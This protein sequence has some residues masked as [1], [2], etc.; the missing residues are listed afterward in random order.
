VTTIVSKLFHVLEPE[1]AFFGQKDAA[2]LAVIRRMVRD[3][4]FAVE[5]VACSI[6]REPDGL[7][8]SS[9]N[10]Y[11]NGEERSRALVLQRSLQETRQRFQAG[12]RIAANLI[13]AANEVIR[14]VPQ[15]AL[16]YFEIVDPETLDP[17][18]RVSQKTLVAVAAYVGS[19]RL[20]DNVVL[21]P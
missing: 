10:A 7:A 14:R 12:E 4:N 9:R 16:D 13:S 6:V 3:L 1:A 17:V 5:I 8:M 11:L 15:V 21:N 20:I 18:E 19:T 2:Q